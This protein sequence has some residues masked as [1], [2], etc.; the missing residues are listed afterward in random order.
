M[1]YMLIMLALFVF[2]ELLQ[3]R[4]DRNSGHTDY[5]PIVFIDRL[6]KTERI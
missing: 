4:A 5:C 3:P 6:F 2:V 1:I